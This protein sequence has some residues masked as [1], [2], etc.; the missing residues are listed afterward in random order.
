MWVSCF[1]RGVGEPPVEAFNRHANRVRS[2]RGHVVRTC[3]VFLLEF[4]DGQQLALGFLPDRFGSGFVVHEVFEVKLL[5]VE[6]AGGFGVV[7]G[8]SAFLEEVDAVGRL[9][10]A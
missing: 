7:K 3:D 5:A 9:A 8:E 2:L 10:V 6:P 1:I 4:V